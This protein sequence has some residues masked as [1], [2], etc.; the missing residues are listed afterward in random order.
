MG[1]TGAGQQHDVARHRGPDKTT[2][3]C[4]SVAPGTGRTGWLSSALVFIYLPVKFLWQGPGVRRLGRN[5][6][7]TPPTT[8]ALRQDHRH[9]AA[10]PADPA[11]HARLPATAVLVL[12][13]C[14]PHGARPPC[15]SVAG[16]QLFAV[17][18]VPPRD[19][20]GGMWGLRDSRC[21][22]DAFSFCPRFF[23]GKLLGWLFLCPHRRDGAAG[24]SPAWGS[25]RGAGEG[26]GVWQAR[27]WGWYI[28]T[29]VPGGGTRGICWLGRNTAV[30][31]RPGWGCRWRWPAGAGLLPGG[32]LCALP[33]GCS[34]PPGKAGPRCIAWV[35]A[36][37]ARCGG[38]CGGSACQGWAGALTKASCSCCQG[39]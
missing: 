34:G 14:C 2:P 27:V 26:G 15:H 11:C 30:A 16:C 36:G 32:W 1:C 29:E 3:P 28:S 7:E 31:A 9:S 21:A 6:P 13:G 33:C 4:P 8:P 23:Q 18:H 5:I 24:A 10:V 22:G 19:S 12:G 20:V 37:L 25:P 35:C 17:P 39:M 38:G